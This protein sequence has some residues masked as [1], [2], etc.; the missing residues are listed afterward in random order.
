MDVYKDNILGFKFVA[1][2]YIF[3]RLSFDEIGCGYWDAFIVID[4]S[5][6]NFFYLIFFTVTA[7]PIKVFLKS[8]Q[9][10]H[11]EEQIL[12][13]TKRTRELLPTIT[14]SVTVPHTLPL[15]EQVRWIT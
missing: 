9:Y 11:I 8:V 12:E 2:L 3:L 6:S 1:L 5:T 4:W 13:L 14:L 15:D 7:H 10:F